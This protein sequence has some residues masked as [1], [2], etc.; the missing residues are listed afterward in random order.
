MGLHTEIVAFCDSETS[1][2]CQ[3]TDR[4]G[5]SIN[6]FSG[7][8]APSS[9]SEAIKELRSWGWTCSSELVCPE[10]KSHTPQP[11]SGRDE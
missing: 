6:A 11:D 7:T 10:C 9:K 3:A 2:D 4:D 5:C 1:P 8:D